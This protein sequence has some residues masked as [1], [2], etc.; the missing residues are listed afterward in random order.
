MWTRAKQSEH[1]CM[2][3]VPRLQKRPRVR[4]TSLLEED[5][6]HVERSETN[7]VEHY[8]SVIC[9]VNRNSFS[10]GFLYAKHEPTARRRERSSARPVNPQA[11]LYRAVCFQEQQLP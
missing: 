2:R 7:K 5:L 11:L 6:Q 9:A 3:I 1:T 10:K 4:L 8:S